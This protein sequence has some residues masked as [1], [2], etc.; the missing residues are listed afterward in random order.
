MSA[1]PGLSEAE[2]AR[3]LEARGPVEPPASSRSP[4]SIVRANVFTVFNVILLAL[5]GLTLAFG[6]WRDA[7]FLGIVVSNAGIGITQ[8]GVASRPGAGSVFYAVLPRE[9]R[10]AA[11]G[12]GAGRN[13]RLARGR[14]E[15]EHGANARRTGTNPGGGR[16][17]SEPEANPRPS[18]G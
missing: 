4:G 17:P 18:R 10:A 1:R 9:A 13:A 16:Q 11:A 5:G 15:T 7:L 3:R 6:D 8:V 2:A 14:A 12:S